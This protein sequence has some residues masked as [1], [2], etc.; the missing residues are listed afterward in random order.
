MERVAVIGNSGGGKSRLARAIAARRGLPYTEVDALLWRPGWRLAEVAAYEAAH[1][2]AIAAPRWVIDGLGRRETIGARL[3]RATEIVLIDL[4]LALHLR[5]AEE[6][7]RAWEAGTLAHPP[8]GLTEAPPLQALLR[9]IGE[10]DRAW[11]PDIRRQAEAA[12][13]RGTPVRRITSIAGLDAA[14]RSG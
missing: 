9:T 1:D 14:L 3:A 13:G 8:G 2:E 10:V 11:M 5:S 4:P 6:R 12:L 7:H